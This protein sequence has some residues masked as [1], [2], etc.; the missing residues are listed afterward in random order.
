MRWKQFLTPVQSMDV[1]E[2]RAYLAGKTLQEVTIL[3][4]RQ[5]GEYEEGHIPGARLVPL[6]A[7][8]DSLDGSISSR[9]WPAKGMTRSST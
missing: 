7:L 9:P 8:T 5:P 4:V 1:G 6:P 3:D 2:V